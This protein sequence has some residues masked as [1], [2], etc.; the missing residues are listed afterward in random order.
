MRTRAQLI[1]N[2]LLLIAALVLVNLIGQRLKFRV[3]LTA[4]KRYSLST[5]TLKLLKEL[6]EAV[7]VTAYF[8]EQMPPDL[9]IARQELKDLLI[10]YATRS[11]GNV[12]FEFIDPN[13][14]DSLEQ[15]AQQEGIRPMIAQTREKDKAENLQVYMGAVVRM[16]DRKAV[17]PVVQQ[18]AALEWTV[19]SAIKQVSMVDKPVIG[20]LQGHGEPDPALM[21]QLVQS[22]GITYSPQPMAIY[23]SLPI[24]DRF[25]ALVIVDPKDSISPLQLQRLD[26]FMRKGKGVVVAY[27]P[28]RSDL[29]TTPVIDIRHTGLEPWLAQHGVRVMDNILVDAR[30]GQVT[31]M[32]QVG[33]FSLPVQ[34]AFPYFPTI[35]DFADN[36]VSKGLDGVSF[37]FC[38]SLI[39]S[40]TDSTLRYTPLLFSSDHSNLLQPPQFIDIRKQWGDADFPLGKQVVAAEV[41]S[42]F[43]G[44]AP[45]HLV[46]FCEGSFCVN[47][48]GQ[49]AVQLPES[50]VNLMVNAID[51]ATGSNDLLGLRGKEIN[52]R[53]IDRLSDGTRTTLKVLNLGLPMLLAIL[54]GLGRR[55]WRRRQRQQRM[56]PGH[57]R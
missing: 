8:T 34:I 25:K 4:D 51:R 7:T 16:G 55:A 12:V 24:N 22:L 41:E 37:H 46:V 20:F 40:G 29:N 42:T 15:K 27:S 50:N 36:P 56:S 6:P 57:V 14:A 38:A 33:N 35:T 23:D 11:N 13:T 43:G 9:A 32:Q 47:G 53:P 18:G 26:E 28:V 5:A 19:S 52:Y 48:G 45:T 30:C 3:D 31:A 17:M 54:Y 49:Q 1:R 21:S 44:T 10:E 2:T 39:A